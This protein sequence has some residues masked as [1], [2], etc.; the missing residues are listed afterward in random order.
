V[1][2]VVI[3]K[4]PRPG[5]VKTRLCPPCSPTEAASLASA[6]L[7]DTLEAAVGSSADEVILALDGE[8]GPWLPAG[9]R[10]IAQ[11]GRGLDERLAC[12]F[13]DV[14]TAVLI[15]MDTPQVTSAL[16]D[17]GLSGLAGP[18]VDAV[19]G[20]ADDGG[21]WALGLRRPDPRAFLGVP[22]SVPTTHAA[23]LDRLVGLGLRIAALPVLRDVDTIHDAIAV[24]A[25]ASDTRFARRL[26][27]MTAGWVRA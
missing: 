20:A 26:A 1:K 14:G 4:A 18:C 9:V 23:Q 7:A 15:G 3:A 2:L 10:V 6:S 5:F 27:I 11:R 8:P 24:A 21:W 25:E 12:A 16:L 22:M 19:V 17:T 13:D